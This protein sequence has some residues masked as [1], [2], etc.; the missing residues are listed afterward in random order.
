MRSI[1]II[2]AG[3]AALALSACG[4][5]GGA[6]L[7]GYYMGTPVTLGGGTATGWVELNSAGTPVSIGVRLTSGALSSLP[8]ADTEYTINFPPQAAGVAVDH[9]SLNWNPSGH[10]PAGIYDVPHFDCHFYRISAAERA[11]IT[12]GSPGF[13]VAPDANEIPS[14]YV[15]SPGS[16][17]PMMGTH[18]GD[19]ASPEFNGSAFTYTF[20]YGFFNGDMVFYEPMIAKSFLDSTNAFQAAV[21][22]PASYPE[23][24]RYPTGYALSRDLATGEIDIKLTGLTQH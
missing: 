16:D 4:G 15:M 6:P 23:A 19:P 10:E 2:L 7:A 5:G 3:L 17:V 8:A 13:A 9:A 14:G 12:P 20:I 1:S 24:G 22:Q 18:Y 21:P 11:A